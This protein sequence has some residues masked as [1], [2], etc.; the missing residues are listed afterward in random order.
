MEWGVVR[1]RILSTRTI[2]PRRHW[3]PHTWAISAHLFNHIPKHTEAEPGQP[4]FPELLLFNLRLY[5]V[6]WSGRDPPAPKPPWA[7]LFRGRTTATQPLQTRPPP[8]F[9]PEYPRHTIVRLRA[10]CLEAATR[11]SPS[12]YPPPRRSF[13]SARISP[14]PHMVDASPASR[15]MAEVAGARGE[16]SACR[17]CLRC[18]TYRGARARAGGPR[19]TAQQST[20][21][22]SLAALARWC[23]DVVWAVGTRCLL[24]V[25]VWSG[26]LATLVSAHPGKAL[27]PDLP[28]KYQGSLCR[29]P[30]VICGRS[31]LRAETRRPLDVKGR[32]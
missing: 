15:T 13:G 24:G 21:R 1:N 2:S 10:S 20:G 3:Y 25:V 22:A 5:L 27:T 32:D 9:W 28:K 6:V 4:Y 18:S 14:L 26:G 11:E 8:P 30:G 17:I 29:A 7:R 16:A 31:G 12:G 23:C 19:V